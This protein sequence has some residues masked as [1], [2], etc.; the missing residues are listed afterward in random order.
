MTTKLNITALFL[1]VC[2]I[3]QFPSVP[4]E[5]REIVTEDVL[6]I[7]VYGQP[8]LSITTRVS[9]EGEISF[10]LLGALNVAGKTVRELEKEIEVLLDKDYIVNPHVAVL[11]TEYHLNIVYV[12][13]EVNA[14]QAIDL[15]MNKVTTILE[16]ISMAGGFTDI[17]NKNKIL[18]IR[19][20]PDGTKENITVKLASIIKKRK[21]GKVGGE[22]ETAIRPGDVIMV[23]ERIF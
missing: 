16:V 23:S 19:T 20:A 11:T 12:M 18:I 3:F 14:P 8:D 6:Q 7:T 17:A 15:T 5:A 9:S 21:K 10:P 13:G 4:C 2:M 1:A 22:D